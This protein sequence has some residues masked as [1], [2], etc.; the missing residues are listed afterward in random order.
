MSSSRRTKKA[1]AGGKEVGARLDAPIRIIGGAFRG[2]TLE[3][4]GDPRTRPMKDRVR[5]AVFNLLGPIEGAHVIDLF[6]GT[7]ALT[8]EAISRGAGSADAVEKHFPTADVLKKNAKSLAP[9]AKVNVRAGDAFYWA[10]RL[11]APIDRPWVVFCCPPYALYVDRRNDLLLTLADM[12]RRAPV[13][14]R[15]VV[16]CDERFDPFDLPRAA[17]WSV[18]TYPPAVIAILR[19]G[20]KGIGLVQS[21]ENSGD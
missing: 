6:S 4:H 12:I 7:G 15:I 17:E 20:D 1:A 14:S 11:E 9:E 18:R 8:L 5:E 16:E 21:E 3:Y 10:T 13:G 19:I 2:R